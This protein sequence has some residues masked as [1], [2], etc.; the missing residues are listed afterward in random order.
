MPEPL[1]TARRVNRGDRMSMAELQQAREVL[2]GRSWFHQAEVEQARHRVDARIAALDP[3]PPPAPPPV[4]VRARDLT[5][6]RK[7]PPPAVAATPRS[8]AARPTRP[9]RDAAPAEELLARAWASYDRAEVRMHRGLET[10]TRLEQLFLT[11]VDALAAA[12]SPQLVHA[13]RGVAL[14]RRYQPGRSADALDA[15]LR[16]LA[17][18]PRCVQAV[19]E[20]V[21][22]MRFWATADGLNDTL[23]NIP[24]E[25]RRERLPLLVSTARGADQWG[26]MPPADGERWLADLPGL[27][28]RLDDQRSLGW[29]LSQQGLEEERTGSHAKAVQLLR[30]ALATGHATAQAVDRLTVRMVAQQEWVEAAAA[31][32][33]ALV[34]SI[35]SDTLRERMAARLRRCERQLTS[36]AP[37]ATDAVTGPAGSVA[38]GIAPSEVRDW[39]R[40]HGYQ[41]GDRGRLPSEVTDAYRRAQRDSAH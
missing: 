35:T 19:D 32:R 16:A 22:F 17:A 7:V 21:D 4:A 31:L 2:S 15:H 34:Q 33:A 38:A 18:D 39:A 29:V 3:T 27:L 6:G 14:T 30:E 28:R 12:Q 26:N 5:A 9:R 10:R 36:A 20:Y 40:N 37:P 25:L 24:V 1:N 11:A 13:W 8:P 23:R 41:V